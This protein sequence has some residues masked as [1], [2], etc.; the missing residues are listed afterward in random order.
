MRAMSPWRAAL[1]CGALLLTGCA[2]H[3]YHGGASMASALVAEDSMTD[4][5]PDR[6]MIWHADLDIEVWNVSNAVSGAI[7]LVEREGG[8]VEAK[9]DRVWQRRKMWMRCGKTWM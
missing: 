8:F 2:K 6:M 3:A 9:S 7:A 5:R 4:V 1:I